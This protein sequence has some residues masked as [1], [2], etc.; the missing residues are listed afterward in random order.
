MKARLFNKDNNRNRIVFHYLL[1]LLAFGIFFSLLWV[2]QVRNIKVNSE[3]V[4]DAGTDYVFTADDTAITGIGL[5]FDSVN[6]DVYGQYDRHTFSGS[7]KILEEGGAMV[8]NRQYQEQSVDVL[9]VSD[10]D[11]TDHVDWL[12]DDIPL[13]KGRPYQ[14]VIQDEEGNRVDDLSVFLYGTERDFFIFYW[15]IGCGILVLLSL[16][17]FS[18]H[19]MLKVSFK[20]VW[21]PALLMIS[22]LE[23]LAMT[24]LCIPDGELH[25]FSSF[26]MSSQIM[27]RIPVLRGLSGEVPLGILRFK[28][29]G[30]PQYAYHF[31]TDWKSG[32]VPTNRAD[33]FFLI[34]LMPHYSYVIPAVGITVAR[35]IHAPWQIYLL[36]GQMMNVLLYGAATLAAVSLKPDLEKTIA[37]ITLLPSTLW[38]VNSFSYDVWNLA[39][40]ILAVA[41]CARLVGQEKVTVWELLAVVILMLA[42]IPLKFIYFNFVLCLFLIRPYQ[43]KVR[44]RKLFI[45]GIIIVIALGIAIVAAARGNEILTFLGEGGFD[46]RTENDSTTTYSLA[47]AVHH[48]ARM[49]LLYLKSIY[50]SGA[51]LFIDT[52]VG[53]NYQGYIPSVL[54]VGIMTAFFIAVGGDAAAV[55]GRRSRA[56]FILILVTGILIVMTSFVFVY[57]TRPESGIGIIAGMQGRY[58]IPYLICLPFIIRPHKWITD[59]GEPALYLLTA[60]TMIS[61][62]ARF[63]G[64][65]MN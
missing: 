56:V 38:L 46:S 10:D 44:N 55:S 60:M 18:W 65:I 1:L 4:L 13:E 30:S 14:V 42:F 59:H 3:T 54:A 33:S 45:A 23:S 5:S 34:G 47:W 19:G 24:P 9:S 52:F 61:I 53:D 8:W 48:P 63:T 26:A 40:I 51:E 25:F 57:S 64:I 7:I 41:W 12:P 43:W 2:F 28:S 6:R 62:L 17:Y 29:F 50:D 15:L 11:Q 31:W 16:L 35:I 32:N 27:N 21:I 20:A 58:F 36:L 39:F 22:L 37:A 49:I